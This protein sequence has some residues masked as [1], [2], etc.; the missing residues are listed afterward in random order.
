MED[1]ATSIRRSRIAL[2]FLQVLWLL[3]VLAN[4]VYARLLP[5]SQREGSRA[6]GFMIVLLCYV[7]S[8]LLSGRV[9][10]LAG[11][12]VAGFLALSAILPILGPL[13]IFFK[14]GAP[15]AETA[16]YRQDPGLRP[17]ETANPATRAA[18]NASPKRRDAIVG[19]IAREG[20]RP[21]GNKARLGEGIDYRAQ[22]RDRDSAER[23]YKSFVSYSNRNPPP[24]LIEVMV[25]YTPNTIYPEKYAFILPYFNSDVPADY[26]EWA[27]GAMQSCTDVQRQHSYSSG[28]SYEYVPQSIGP[29]GCVLDW[30]IIPPGKFD[31]ES[32]EMRKLLSDPPE[33]GFESVHLEGQGPATPKKPDP[34][35]PWV[36][37]LFDIRKF[38]EAWYGRAATKLL[39][40]LLGGEKLSGSVIHGGDLLPDCRY[41]CN[42][43]HAASL[44]QA[45]R[46][47][48]A[49]IG[50]GN[51]KLAKNRSP[52][53]R[54][55][56]L[57]VS[58]L[59]FQG[60][61][62]ADGGYV[63]N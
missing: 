45:D 38:D 39:L 60:F 47:E 54:G 29:K 44:E 46:I 24:M 50:S 41:W 2:L 26:Q 5:S 22:F 56:E 8:L 55:D 6:I 37:V 61:V 35:G 27:R 18:P 53:I 59:P 34:A 62:G 23:F 36:G 21:L 7:A 57:D 12:S 30:T 14:T 9:A 17:A 32:G 49:V 58:A 63:G 19:L 20:L 1:R 10:S 42:A 15:R 25:A 11:K 52:V 33:M 13:V 4:S 16:S 43:V 40:D 28:N 3:S 51:E 48:A 31:P